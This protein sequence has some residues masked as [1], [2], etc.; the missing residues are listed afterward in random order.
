MFSFLKEKSFIFNLLI[1]M[2]I[3]FV[4]IWL[5]IFSINNFTR[6]GQAI[7]VPDLSGLYFSELDENDEYE[8]FKFL[9]VD[10]I[11]DPDKE[12][13]TIISQDPAPKSLVKEDRMIYLTVVAVNPKMI[14]MPELKDLSLRSASS[15][16]QT[17]NLKIGK[18]TYEPDYAS[19]AVLRQLYKGS[20]IEPGKMIKA[21]STIDLVLGLGEEQELIPVPMIIGLTRSQAIAALH[22]Y[23]LNIGSESFEPG[24][25]T[26]KVRIYRQSPN[27]TNQSVSRF[28]SS[29]DVWYK[30]DKNFDFDT[31]LKSIKMDSSFIETN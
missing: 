4:L 29:V 5:T 25:D 8:N 10:S 19:N 18:L 6:H 3:I 1:I 11:Y 17:Y 27:F 28:G 26:S 16:L 23:S 30:S 2:G 14:E 31:Y 24:D 22:S 12:K 20:P 21:G 9:I 13:G 7:S 15:L